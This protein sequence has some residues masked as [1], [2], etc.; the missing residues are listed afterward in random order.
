[1]GLIRRRRLQLL[2]HSCI[3]YEYDESIISDNTWK[4]WAME[5][6]EL[7]RDY[8][9]L[10]KQVCWHQK[11]IGFDHSTGFQLPTKDPWVMWKARH[12]LRLH[13]HHAM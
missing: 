3:Y 5:L 2:V 8:P 4:T 7:Q 1:M 6:E 9:E 13:E 11:F 10:C 12:L